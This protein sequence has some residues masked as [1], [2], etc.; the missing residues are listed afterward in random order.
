[1][2]FVPGR[3]HDLFL[4]YK[5]DESAW[6]ET[7]RKALCEAFA[8]KT[9]EHLSFW[10]DKQNIR[11]SQKWDKE[12]E[13]AIRNTAVFLAIVSPRY[14]GSEW[15]RNE[16]MIFLENGIDAL[17]VDTFY[18]LLKVVKNPGTNRDSQD[19]LDDLEPIRFF[20]EDDEEEYPPESPEFKAAIRKAF[21]SLHEILTRMSN[22]RQ[23]LYVAPG[24]VELISER[25]KLIWELKDRGYDVRKGALLG[26]GFKQRAINDAMEAASH[27]LLLIASGIDESARAHFRAAATL[28]KPVLCWLRPG[29][30][31]EKTVDEIHETAELPVG[32]EI[33]GGNSIREL[34]PQLFE[35]LKQERE[36]AMPVA[37]ARGAKEL[38]LN[39]DR[40]MPED[41]RTAITVGELARSRSFKVL[42]EGKDGAHEGLMERAS[43][44]L[45]L[46]P[47]EPEPDQWLRFF[48]VELSIA[49]LRY[50]RPNQ[51]K[52]LLV[53]DESL[54]RRFAP[55][56]PVYAWKEPF[57]AET[58]NPFFDAAS[59]GSGR[60]NAG[61]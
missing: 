2:A 36:E 21:K 49:A 41:R 55:G 54:A 18:R 6:V 16:Y 26:P 8:N 7:F 60:A 42:R 34:I 46:R 30:D 24:G 27:V 45:V 50:N 31:R 12:I 10:Q 15:C 32:S 58:L 5:Q 48:A 40:S 57:S 25:E 37:S 1:M 11:G 56:I 52:A 19:L 20:A 29:R 33:L 47:S 3:K 38:Y 53:K 4:S 13:Q 44:V 9:G 61:R 22:G 59:R 39:F 28:K 43:A 51:P 17:K 14:L 23:T 35:R